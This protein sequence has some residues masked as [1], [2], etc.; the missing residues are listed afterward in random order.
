MSSSLIVCNS[1]L[2]LCWIVMC[3]EKWIFYD[4][5][6]IPA[7]R[8]NWEEAPK[9]FRN[10]NLY[11]K[12]IMVTGGLLLIWSTTAFWI[13]A[14]L[15]YLR[16]M[17]SKSVSYPE[18][19]NTCSQH[20]PTE[21]TQFFS[22]PTPDCTSHNQHFK[23]W[24]NWAVEFC[25]ICHIHLTSCQPATTPLSILATFCRENDSTTSIRQKMLSKSLSNP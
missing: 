25:L 3:N 18:N 13:P 22:V 1:E 16:S 4:N 5:W 21:R 15:L 14:K 17:L 20:W 9:H 23:S 24:M 19:C 11:Q 6:Q 7:Q 10:Q 2:F 12:K 8:L